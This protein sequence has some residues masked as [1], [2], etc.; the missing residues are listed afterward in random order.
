MMTCLSEVMFLVR[1]GLMRLIS[2]DVRFGEVMFQMML[3]LLRLY[4]E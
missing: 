3:G 4:F 1:L 2:S